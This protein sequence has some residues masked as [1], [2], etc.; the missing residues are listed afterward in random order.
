MGRK[1]AR[2]S[3]EFGRERD[4]E[5]VVIYHVTQTMKLLKQ[6]TSFQSS[7]QLSKTH[8][9]KDRK[10]EMCGENRACLRPLIITSVGAEHLRSLSLLGLGGAIIWLTPPRQCLAPAGPG[11]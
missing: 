7:N 6:S 4:Q 9:R 2:G 1:V 8:V 3:H 5:S 11:L 10:Q